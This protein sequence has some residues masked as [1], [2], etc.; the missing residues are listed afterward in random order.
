MRN[1]LPSKFRTKNR[2]EIN[3]K[4]KWRC[5][6]SNI[7]FKTTTIRSSLCNYSDLYIL[8][9]ETITVPN[10]AAVGTAVNNTNKKVIF[11]NCVPFTDCI[12]E[13]NNTEIDDAQKIDVLMSMYILTEYSKTYLKTSG[14]LWQ[15]YRDEPALNNN[16][17]IIGF[18]TD[19]NSASFKFKQKIT[20]QTGNG[21]TKDVEIMVPLKYL[22]SF[23]RTMEMPL[24][25]LQLKWS[26][27]CIIV[28]GTANNQNLI[29]QINYTKIYVPNVTL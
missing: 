4:S 5:D 29:F 10:T 18:P 17:N 1:S 20:V 12:T 6:N 14:N 3:D 7:R 26:K 23:W 11:K 2:V 19:N 24:I 25:S 21:G 8:V 27:K 15:Y 13:I 22:S 9:K 16:V 28:A